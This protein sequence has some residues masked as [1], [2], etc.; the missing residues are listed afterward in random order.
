MARE[1]TPQNQEAQPGS[2]AKRDRD[3]GGSPR[4]TRSGQGQSIA[5]REQGGQGGLVPFATPF[6]FMR[7]FMDDLDRLFFERIDP[8]LTSALDFSS[9]PR[10]GGDTT[11]SPAVEVLEQDGLV[12]VR[13]DVPGMNKDDINIEVVGDALVISGERCQEREQNE[14]GVYRSECVYGRFYR[15]VPLPEGIDPEQAKANFKNGV[16]EIKIP[17]PEQSRSRRIQIADEGQSPQPQA[18][19]Q[20]SKARDDSERTSSRRI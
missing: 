1:N 14:G 6:T 11:W 9:T 19:S 18:Q 12:V 13:A 20:Q 4:T 16:L 7:R 17:A 3:Q 15:A 8:S 2:G 5:G 10:D